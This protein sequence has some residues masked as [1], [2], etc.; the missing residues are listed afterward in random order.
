MKT[1]IS[2]LSYTESLNTTDNSN[3]KFSTAILAAVAIAASVH[4]TPLARR[5]VDP[6]LVP[7]FGVQAGVN[8]DGTGYAHAFALTQQYSR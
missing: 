1:Y 7:A 3:M 2:C 5:D 8:P 4:S 6:S